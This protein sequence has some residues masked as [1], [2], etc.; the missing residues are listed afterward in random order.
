MTLLQSLGMIERG[1][2]DTGVRRYG[3]RKI[4]VRQIEV[5][6]QGQ[7]SP[8]VPCGEFLDFK[9]GEHLLD[10]SVGQLASLDASGGANT[11]DGGNAPKGI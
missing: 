10:L 9:A 6:M 4:P 8:N 2:R 7:R 11:L 3:H 5:A 1:G